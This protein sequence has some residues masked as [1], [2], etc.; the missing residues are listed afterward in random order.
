MLSCPVLLS[1][2]HIAV[3][4]LWEKIEDILLDL[5]YLGIWFVKGFQEIKMALIP[6]GFMSTKELP[7]TTLATK[8]KNG[9][10]KSW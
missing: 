6:L 5:I 10:G 3:N 4:N 9:K 8:A 7:V 2:Q 1:S